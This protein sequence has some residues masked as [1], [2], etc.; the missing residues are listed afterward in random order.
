MADNHVYMYSSQHIKEI[1][2]G[3]FDGLVTCN[4]ESEGQ[5]TC[6]PF[7][8]GFSKSCSHIKILWVAY[9]VHEIK[10]FHTKNT[11]SIILPLRN[12][13]PRVTFYTSL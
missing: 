1:L 9:I 11:Q 13:A 12:Y 7:L 8:C 2:W 3:H 5:L 4:Q 10:A 6:F